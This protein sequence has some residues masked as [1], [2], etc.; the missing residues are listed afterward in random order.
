MGRGWCV[1][2][3]AAAAWGQARPAAPRYATIYGVTVDDSGSPV[4]RAVVTL[5]T[6]TTEPLE[7]VAWTD[8]NGSFSFSWVPAG[9][10]FLS[11]RRDGYE[12]ARYGAVRREQPPEILS[13]AAGEQR[14]VVLRLRRVGS[15]SGT[16]SDPEGDPL[17]GVNVR[18][19]AA[20]YQRRKA[21]YTDAGS[22][23]TDNRGRYRISGLSAGK[24]F[25]MVD[26]YAWPQPA[27]G[28]EAVRGQAAEET[29]YGPQFYPGVD[30]ISAAAPITLAAGKNLDD[31][32]FHMSPQASTRIEGK[33]VMPQDVAL[34]PNVSPTVQVFDDDGIHNGLTQG[35]GVRQPDGT[36]VA[37]NLLPGR[38]VLC[39]YLNAQGRAYRGVERVDLGQSP[40]HVTI[41]L[42]PGVDLSGS[43]RLEGAAGGQAPHFRVWLSPGDRLPS[44]GPMPEAQIKPDGTFRIPGVLA[45][46]WDI[47]VEPVPPGGYIKSMRLGDQ[48]V[49]T[50]EMAI[51]SG[52]SQPLNIVVSTRGAVIDG[53]VAG[54]GGE[55]PKKAYVLLAPTGRWESVWSFY[56][57]TPSDEK[58]HFEFKG[59]TPGTYRLYALER[60]DSD[61]S[62]NPDFLKSL[63]A[64]WGEAV[65]VGEGAHVTR[66]L[67][68]IPE[69]T[70]AAE[71]K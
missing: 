68:L 1:L 41:T 13:L 58:G 4:P 38:Y 32:D 27:A 34:G 7:A 31:F 29:R 55:T 14:R 61:P 47:G 2:A 59:I 10:Y 20:G 63:G 19:L 3:L 15:I 25:L 8:N 60:M 22:G 37:S 71:S 5:Q 50:E 11:A 30:R 51:N 70:L 64:A 40:A 39:A 48:D 67:H 17:P 16:V 54:S 45:G 28:S 23:A 56:Q 69:E 44:F 35:A 62:Q 52:T 46:V 12:M 57:V 24:Y 42:D 53:S 26:P 65:E 43:V 6:K 36:F 33:V 21:A 18:L 9:Q 66:E 49:L